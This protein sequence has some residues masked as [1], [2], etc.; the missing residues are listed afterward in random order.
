M[1]KTNNPLRLALA[2]LGG[3]MAGAATAQDCPIDAP[4]EIDGG[5]Y[6]LNLP[7]G[8]GPHPVLIWYHG[9]NSTGQSIHRGGGLQRDF[10]DRGYAL[11]APNGQ[12]RAGRNP[13]RFFFPGRD[14]SA[15]DDVAFTFAALADAQ[16][17]GQLDGS[18]LYVGGFSAGGSMAW[19]LACE[20]GDRLS[21]M[22]SVAGALRRPN[23]T[24]CSGLVGLPVMQIHGFADGQVPLEGRGIRDWHQGSVWVSLERARTANGCRT[25]PDQIDIA[26]DF[27]ARLWD[28]S[29][30]RAPVRIDLHD[31]GHGLP[32]GWTARARGFFEDAPS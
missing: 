17:R 16:Q 31:G 28:A 15:R 4:C 20:A 11:L 18:R 2:F 27:R 25:N 6:Y 10:L 19:L 26:D 29:C 3:W 32:Q 23:S 22:V 8:E 30:A 24:D 13:E 12:T 1:I 9:A 5:S 7:E 14:G 21:G